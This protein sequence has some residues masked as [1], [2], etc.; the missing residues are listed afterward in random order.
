[1]VNPIYSVDFV[2]GCPKILLGNEIRARCDVL[3]SWVLCR[4]YE[5]AV[6]NIGDRAVRHQI[7]GDTANSDAYSFFDQAILFDATR[8]SK[9][10][11]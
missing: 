9:I 1:M 5:L 6:Y 10:I 7:V 11:D 8:V 4:G 3:E 2:N